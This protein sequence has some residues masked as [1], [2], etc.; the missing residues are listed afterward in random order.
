MS[1]PEESN[2]EATAR[3]ALILLR[4]N[5][6]SETLERLHRAIER[7]IR[8]ASRA[9][10]RASRDG[11]LVEAIV[12]EEALAVEELLGLAFVAAQS[13]ITLIRTELIA[14]NKSHLLYLG[15][16]LTFAS[17]AKAYDA[18]K[19]GSMLTGAKCSEVEAINA[20][21]NYWKH[22]EEW[23][24]VQTFRRLPEEWDLNAFQANHKRTV[25]IVIALGLK[26]DSDGNLRRAAKALGVA[27]FEDLSPLRDI[28]KSWA[29][30]LL[31]KARVEFG[32]K[33]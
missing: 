26:P 13:F 23:P 21:A 9:I 27:D 3:H 18:L 8:A 29:T 5:S 17:D 14:V 6:Q 19:I 24:V 10:Q 12:G 15:S 25:Q 2:T 7:E 1:C 32:V 4:I 16:P 22:S 28:L 30:E 11:D 20:I 31:K 33:P